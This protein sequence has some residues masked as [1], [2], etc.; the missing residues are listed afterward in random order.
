M[1]AFFKMNKYTNG[2]WPLSME[3]NN[4]FIL[5]ILLFFF[6]MLG[7]ENLLGQ[8][9]ESADFKPPK[10]RKSNK[11]GFEFDPSNIVVGGN[12]GAAFGD[13]TIVE[14]SPTV[15]YQFSDHYVAGLSAKYIYFE[16]RQFAPVFTYKTN[17]YGGGIYNQYYFLENFIAHAEYELINRDHPFVLNKRINVHGVFVGGGYRSGND[18]YFFSLLVL[19]NLNDSPE[20]IYPNPNIRIGFGI[21]FN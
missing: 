20:S 8:A 11:G 18:G 9:R 1:Q 4:R 6:L 7:S 3:I 14:V 5:S 2:T 13:I 10:E 17:V 15:G 21:G 12:F 19:Y 16:D